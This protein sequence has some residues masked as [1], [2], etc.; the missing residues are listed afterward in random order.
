MVLLERLW[1]A[2]RD[3]RSKYKDFDWESAKLQGVRSFCR[4]FT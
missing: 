4:L 2:G 3:K 1:Y